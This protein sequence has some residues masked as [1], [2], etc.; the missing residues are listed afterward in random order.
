MSLDE[1]VG[2]F[3]SNQ[4]V[5][6]NALPE[7]RVTRDQAR[8]WV[9]SFLA[10]WVDKARSIQMKRTMAEM[11]RAAKSLTM[12]TDVIEG[13]A[14]G[15]RY[16]IAIVNAWQGLAHRKLWAA[17]IQQ[18]WLD[19]CGPRKLSEAKKKHASSDRQNAYRWFMATRGPFSE[20]C[21]SL[22]LSESAIRSE[23]YRQ[24]WAMFPMKQT[25]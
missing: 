13:N 2:V 9:N 11:P 22:G 16:H 14:E 18:A 15:D 23:V 3:Y 21:Q 24:Y 20:I 6:K 19:A 5:K 7:F 8:E 25:A 17:F 1:T 10:T 12:G 4:T